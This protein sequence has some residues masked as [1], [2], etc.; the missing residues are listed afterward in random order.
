MQYLIDRFKEPST[1]RGLVALGM[2]F[3]VH[4]SP[5]QI[6]AIVAA[7]MGLIGLIAVFLPDKFKGQGK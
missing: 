5:D 6:N 2:A 1:W 7:G 4:L 3:G